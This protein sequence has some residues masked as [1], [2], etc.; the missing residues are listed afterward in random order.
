[1]TQIPIAAIAH[2]EERK[3]QAGILYSLFHMGFAI[4]SR[5]NNWWGLTPSL[6]GSVLR[7]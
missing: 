4:Y 1:M 3:R 2:N 6:S 5:C 7:T